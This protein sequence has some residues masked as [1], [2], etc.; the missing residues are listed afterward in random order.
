MR[1]R[2]PKRKRVGTV[3]ANTPP[4][5][6]IQSSSSTQREQEIALGR[7]RSERGQ[8]GRAKQRRAEVKNACGRKLQQS[9]LEERQHRARRTQAEHGDAD[10]HERVVIP[11]AK[12]E[13]LGQRDLEEERRG[14]N[15]E[16]AEE[17]GTGKRLSCCL[18]RAVAVDSFQNP[19]LPAGGA[20]ACAKRHRWDYCTVN[21]RRSSVRVSPGDSENEEAWRLRPSRNSGSCDCA[22]ST[23]S[24][25][26]A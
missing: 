21:K 12:G 1:R 11:K 7:Q 25:A 24:S 13:E 9:T 22:G 5:R 26:I 20:V 10:D 2:L 8:R 3:R 17:H 15:G 23:R 14:G 19:T 6:R 16:D 4:P 18:R